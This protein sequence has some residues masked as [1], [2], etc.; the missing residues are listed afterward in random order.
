MFT[1]AP[2][3]LEIGAHPEA[4]SY[5]G[6]GVVHRLVTKLGLPEQIDERLQPLKVHLPYHESDHVLNLAYNALCGGTRLQDIEIRRHDPAYMNAVG[7]ELIPDPTTTGDFCRRFHASDV[8]DL[9]EAINAV[10]PKMWQGRGQDLLGA[11]AYL[12]V[13]GVLAPTG[14][15]RK[16]GMDISYKGIWGYHPLIVSLA[17]TREV[18][19]VVNRPGNVP[20]HTEAACLDRQGDP[21]RSPISAPLP[22]RRHRLFV[23]APFR[24]LGGTGRFVFGM[25]CIGYAHP[26][27]GAR[28]GLLAA[29]AAALEGG[30]P[31]RAPARPGALSAARERAYR[32]R[33]A[34]E[35]VQ[36][37]YE[38][39]AEFEYQPRA[40]Q[41][42]YRVVALRKNLS[43]MKG[44]HVLFEE[45]RYFFYI[46]TRTDLSAAEVVACANQRCD[47]E[48]VIEQLKNGVNALRVPLYDLV[49][50]W[51]YMVMVTLAWNLKSWCAMMMHRK[52]DRQEYVNMEFVDSCLIL[53]P[54]RVIRQARGLCACSAIRRPW[55][56]SLVPG[57]PSNAR[58]S[59]AQS[60]R[61][62][63]PDGGPTGP[64]LAAVCLHRINK[65]PR[66]LVRP[67]GHRLPRGRDQRR[68]GKA[69]RTMKV[70]LEE[71]ILGLV[72]Y[73]VVSR[74]VATAGLATA[75][76]P[77]VS[78]FF[79]ISGMGTSLIGT[80]GLVALTFT[81]VWQADMRVFPMVACANALKLAE[82]IPGPKG[83]LFWGMLAASFAA[84]RERPGSS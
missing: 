15:E 12:D 21:C 47:Q 48:N 9:M 24:P 7:A 63:H 1:A 30:D 44:E 53:I 41:R 35:N 46:T 67:R 73:L 60:R 76:A 27:R 82:T 10:R 20:S 37:N 14:G 22:A 18:L 43:K 38:D 28:G 77:M 55:I 79:V 17:N 64:T 69:Q 45:I 13:D 23:D 68:L 52:S 2:V 31:E 36:L 70:A 54:C 62:R 57:E 8:V 56:D 59:D 16:Q 39:V 11:V 80:K 33:A 19:Y 65:V 29:L 58:C 5:G 84:W 72:F 26:C 4:M 42:S 51:A 50:N 75:R 49:S 6:I 78:A 25:D 66:T 61:P 34:F 71:H 81:Y 40:C 32:R 3:H 83:R 74:V